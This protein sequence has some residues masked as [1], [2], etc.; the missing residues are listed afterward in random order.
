[1]PKYTISFEEGAPREVS[2]PVTVQPTVTQPEGGEMPVYQS[3]KGAIARE[4]RRT[5]ATRG[6]DYDIIEALAG[7]LPDPL[8]TGVEG[9]KVGENTA[10]S[11]EEAT[12]LRDHTGLVSSTLQLFSGLGAEIGDIYKPLMVGVRYPFVAAK[13]LSQYAGGDTEGAKKTLMNPEAELVSFQPT[14][15]ENWM[16]NLV[17]DV[18]KG[19]LNQPEMVA[20]GLTGLVP[21]EKAPSVPVTLGRVRPY[22]R[23]MPREIP[24]EVPEP[25][26]GPE[27]WKRPETVL[28]GEGE[29]MPVRTEAP[30]LEP[31]IIQPEA[32]PATVSEAVEQAAQKKRRIRRKPG[33][34]K[35]I[36]EAAQ[37]KKAEKQV[38]AKVEEVKPAEE[39][40]P[41]QAP[42]Q[43]VP[44]TEEPLAG[45]TLEE[46]FKSAEEQEARK[47]KRS[48]MF[49]TSYENARYRI[50]SGE[51]TLEEA[52]ANG[53][54]DTYNAL[55]DDFAPGYKPRGMGGLSE[56]QTAKLEAE[57]HAQELK[58][59]QSELKQSR[60][61]ANLW[62]DV[63]EEGGLPPIK[64]LKSSKK[65]G[66]KS[67]DIGEARDAYEYSTIRNLIGKNQERALD[68]IA[69]SLQDKGYTFQTGDDL[70]EAL[71]QTHRTGID[72]NG[73]RVGKGQINPKTGK[74]WKERKEKRRAGPLL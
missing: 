23:P 6:L 33:V 61:G 48:V 47:P 32:E 63:M 35:A 16:V 38:A 40:P 62:T 55:I 1:M 27:V 64:R 20:L 70:L 4:S 51:T 11:I 52:I 14:K 41:P 50:E 59:V 8:K 69:Q 71:K 17:G 56:R 24:T 57:S 46:V 53:W 28:P 43:P 31:E 58:D 5:P 66:G 19:A 30:P 54:L 13:A 21:K 22:S 3:R 15:T 72:P 74:A 7:A 9:M 29:T 2:E 39:A 65:T 73:I 18:S 36:R 37:K 49:P 12:G 68:Q 10:K 44:P 45:G 25:V 67:G 26:S 60:S 42:E 34:E